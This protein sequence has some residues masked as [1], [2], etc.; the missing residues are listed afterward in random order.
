[1]T[2]IATLPYDY[3]T[4]IAS[5]IAISEQ[6]SLWRYRIPSNADATTIDYAG[7]STHTNKLKALATDNSLWPEDADPPS[8]LALAW[9]NVV[10]NQLCD[11][12][13]LPTRIVASAEGGVGICFVDG[14]RYADIECLN[15]GAILGVISNRSDRPIVWSVQQ[16][17]RGI[18]R[19]S[20]RIREFMFT[21]AARTNASRRPWGR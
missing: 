11:D 12:N 3:P 14:N 15:T 18:A 9:A 1:M 2:S 16:D 7:F 19:A 20:E 4:E 17:A 21:S 8:E 5:G 13:L 10:I 6:L